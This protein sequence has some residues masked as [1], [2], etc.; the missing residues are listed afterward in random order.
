MIFLSAAIFL[1]HGVL[2]APWLAAAG[3]VNVL[4]VRTS[5]GT[6]FKG[7][8]REKDSTF[9]TLGAEDGSPLNLP[10]SEIRT[11]NGQPMAAFFKNFRP[12]IPDS[13]FESLEISVNQDKVKAK[14]KF[15]TSWVKSRLP[16]GYFLAGPDDDSRWE[17]FRISAKL[18]SPSKVEGELTY[19]ALIKRL[20]DGGNKIIS[21]SFDNT[22]GV[23]TLRTTE[24]LKGNQTARVLRQIRT[25]NGEKCVLE[26]LLSHP[27]PERLNQH[28][29]V[30]LFEKVAGSFRFSDAPPK[31]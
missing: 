30:S 25:V 7:S 16:D 17:G 31:P 5:D 4:T 19:E 26:L 14:F 13:Q 27:S 22:L 15:L 29:V 21:Q 20:S 3:D 8:F 12:V 9:L 10:L 23:K 11:V 1:G 24:T 2:A 18:E 28:M 6:V